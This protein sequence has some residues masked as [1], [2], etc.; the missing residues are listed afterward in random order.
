MV[1]EQSCFQSL[2]AKGNTTVISHNGFLSTTEHLML[3]GNLYWKKNALLSLVCWQVILSTIQCNLW[4]KNVYFLQSY[5]IVFNSLREFKM[6]DL[7]PTS[8]VSIKFK[9]M[10][11]LWFIQQQSCIKVNTLHSNMCVCVCVCVCVFVCTYVVR[12]TYSPLVKF[13]SLAITRFLS[14]VSSQFK[15]PVK[16]SRVCDLYRTNIC[17][18]SPVKFYF[19]CGY[20]WS[21]FRG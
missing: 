18:P 7:F 14:Q 15:L 17:R 4:G 5:I 20:V 10:C 19:R 1:T 13:F 3:W 9:V 21:Y 2:K 6:T 12:H 8:L 11:G 16:Y